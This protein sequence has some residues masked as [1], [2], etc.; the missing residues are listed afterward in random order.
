LAEI[1]AAA[2]SP[3]IA[4]A[5]SELFGIDDFSTLGLPLNLDSIFA[6]QEYIKW[7]SLRERVDSRFIGLTLPKV[8]MRRPYRTKPGSYK[9]IFFHE[10]HV[11]GNEDVYLWGNASYAFGGVLI[12]EFANVG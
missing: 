5:S 6:Q 7:R 11:T 12:R 9:G 10:K 3:F 1:A 4:N 8:L 2:F